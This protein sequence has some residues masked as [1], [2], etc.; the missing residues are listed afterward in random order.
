[1][2]LRKTCSYTTFA[3]SQGKTGPDGSDE[4]KRKSEYADGVVLPYRCGTN[5]KVS[6]CGDFIQ[7]NKASLHEN[8]PMPTTKQTL[9]KLASARVISKLD[10]N[11]GFWQRKLKD[12]SKFLTTFATPWDQYCYMH[13][14][15]DISS[16]PEH[17]QKSMQGIL[18]GLPS[19][20]CQMDDIIV[21]GANQAEYDN[22]LEAVLTQLQDANVMLNCD[23]CEF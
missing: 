15:F 19:V 20:E 12:S 7:L 9:G 16:A 23:K 4:G 14:P 13:L 22:R 21:H 11:S 8:H 3:E 18:E 1:M 6:I 5:G 2:I 17:F 10:A